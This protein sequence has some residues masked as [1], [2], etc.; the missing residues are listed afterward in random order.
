MSALFGR[1]EKYPGNSWYIR[2]LCQ[3]ITADFEIQG[4]GV[5]PCSLKKLMYP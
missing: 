3:I 4:S 2:G 5:W 1:G